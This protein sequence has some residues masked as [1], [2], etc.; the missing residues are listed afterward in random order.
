VGGEGRVIALYHDLRPGKRSK[1]HGKAHR[2]LE[3]P[4]GTLRETDT[5]VGD[6]LTLLPLSDE[7]TPSAGDNDDR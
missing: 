4:V 6:L 7:R 1:Y 2:A 5:R 3:L